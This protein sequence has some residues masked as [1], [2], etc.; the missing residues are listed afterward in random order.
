[1]QILDLSTERCIVTGEKAFVFT[2]HLLAVDVEGQT[3]KVMAG[4]RDSETSESIR[5]TPGGC[6]GDWR[7]EYGI[8]H[9]PMEP[10][11]SFDLTEGVCA[12]EQHHSD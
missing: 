4:F 5:S 8:Q 11:D 3:I 10:D 1:M 12:E 7:G 9:S 6:F 2:G